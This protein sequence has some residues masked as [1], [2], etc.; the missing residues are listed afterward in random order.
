MESC[1]KNR[2]DAEEAGMNTHF[3]Y[4][5]VRIA[6]QSAIA[7]LTTQITPT[8]M[9]MVYQMPLHTISLQQLPLPKTAL[10][11]YRL[12]RLRQEFRQIGR[13][14]LLPAEVPLEVQCSG[15]PNEIVSC[16]F[17]RETF[18][19]YA[20]GL[21]IYDERLLSGYLDIRQAEIAN[22][23]IRLGRELRRPSLGHRTMIDVLGKTVIIELARFLNEQPTRSTPY[24]GGLSHRQIR[25]INDYVEGQ[26]DSPTLSQLSALVGI[27]R[28][29]LTRAFKQTTGKT[30]YN[31][32]EHVRL[33]KAQS[34]LSD[35][36]WLLKDIAHRL[37]FSCSSSFSL[38]FRRL[39][40]E[41]PQDYRRRAKGFGASV[42]LVETRH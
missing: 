31:Y 9:E 39:A 33:T 36:D 29:H 23:L 17:S 4:Q 1:L 30:V 37:G 14:M 42:G 19:S 40:G 34:L 6:T 8:P 20:D 3:K 22:A 28:R 21:D 38:A 5:T 12:P 24:S 16:Q 27:S 32:I 2:E 13:L 41:T 26:Q 35:T 7:D 15:G 18:E 10:A 11:R 25:Q